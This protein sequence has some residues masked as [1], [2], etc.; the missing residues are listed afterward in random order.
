M[1]TKDHGKNWKPDLFWSAISSL[2]AYR[3]AMIVDM[4][5]QMFVSVSKEQNLI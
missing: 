3:G 2:I 4:V 5:S 1:I